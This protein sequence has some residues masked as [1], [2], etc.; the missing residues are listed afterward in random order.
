MRVASPRRKKWSIPQFNQ[1]FFQLLVVFARG[2]WISLRYHWHICIGAFLII[3][4]FESYLAKIF[5]FPPT[6]LEFLL[7]SHFSK[8]RAAVL[9]ARF[10]S[11]ATFLIIRFISPTAL[12]LIASSP[13]SAFT[14]LIS[15]RSFS[16][17]SF[18]NP[19]IAL[20]SHLACA[21]FHYA[22]CSVF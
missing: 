18:C 16:F 2:A 14:V 22:H 7:R 13:F 1:R 9:L 19:S 11:S 17:S 6:L 4:V 20:P 21:S 15:A 5:I 3:E 12:P 10:A 8:L